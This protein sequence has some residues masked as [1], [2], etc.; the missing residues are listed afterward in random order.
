MSH[1][2]HHIPGRLRIKTLQLKRNEAK[3]AKVCKLLAATPGVLNCEVKTLTGSVVISYDASR[4]NSNILVSLLQDHGYMTT[5]TTM[6][7]GKPDGQLA[8]TVSAATENVG[9]ALVG[10]VVERSAAALIGAIL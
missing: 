7:N 10:F 1:Y 4:T 3:A 5:K 2:I 9:K 6:V 8:R